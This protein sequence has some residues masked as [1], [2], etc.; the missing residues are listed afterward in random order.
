MR[1]LPVLL[2]EE[3]TSRALAAKL[4]ALATAQRVREASGR[5]YGEVDL[6]GSYGAAPHPE[7]L[8]AAQER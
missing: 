7:N 4:A 5:G 3:A 8:A 6:V 2:I 1:W